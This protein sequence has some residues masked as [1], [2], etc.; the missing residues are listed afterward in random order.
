MEPEEITIEDLSMLIE[1]HQKENAQL[2]QR[3]AELE[4]IHVTIIK[5]NLALK[6]VIAEISSTKEI[7]NE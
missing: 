5:D 1:F 4:A 6:Q 7:S 3:I 2:K